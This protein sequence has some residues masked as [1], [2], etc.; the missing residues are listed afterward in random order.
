[1]PARPLRVVSGYYSAYECSLSKPDERS[2]LLSPLVVAVLA[3]LASLASFFSNPPTVRSGALA[4]ALAPALAPALALALTPAPKLPTL[5]FLSLQLSPPAPFGPEPGET[6][7]PADFAL[8]DPSTL[9]RRYEPG[10]LARSAPP[11]VAVRA[12]RWDLSWCDESRLIGEGRCGMG[13]TTVKGDGDGSGTDISSL[14]LRQMGMGRSG[15][16]DDDGRGGG[17]G[18]VIHS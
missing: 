14:M 16:A 10:E 4:L 8:A 2:R 6:P 5:P 18:V 3:L 11:A 9:G 13:L 1:V 17:A 12:C 7:S 15:S